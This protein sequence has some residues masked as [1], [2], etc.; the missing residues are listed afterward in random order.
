MSHSLQKTIDEMID[1]SFP[2]LKNK[3][4]KILTI[5]K[6]LFWW[7]TA[8]IFGRFILVNSDIKKEDSKSLMGLLAHELCHIEDSINRNSFQ[9]ISAF[10]KEGFGWLFN[11]DYSRKIE[12]QTD[13]KTIKK[14]YGKELLHLEK[15]REKNFSKRKL[16][17]IHSHGYL[18]SKEIKSLM[19]K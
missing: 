3:N 2:K 12:S 14:G 13:I 15:R 9:E 5:P 19:K 18:S 6:W 4:V 1:N 17:K 11:T 8:F 10:T 16:D 7:A